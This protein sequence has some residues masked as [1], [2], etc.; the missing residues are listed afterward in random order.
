MKRCW[1]LNPNNRPNAI[2]LEKLINSYKYETET[3]FKVAEEYRKKN[4]LSFENNLST[5]THSQA[6]Y[7]SRLLNP[8]TKDLPKHID[9]NELSS[10]IT[11]YN[12]EDNENNYS[13]MSES[14]EKCKIDEN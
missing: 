11:I 4:L 9:E 3:K 6:I 8:F 2:E 1:D 13:N 14:I 12:N 10:K 5:T 7:T